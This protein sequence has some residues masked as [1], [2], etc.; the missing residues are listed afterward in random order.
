MLRAMPKTDRNDEI[1][2][3]GQ[4]AYLADQV[5]KAIRCWE[6]LAVNGHKQSQ[7]VLLKV[8]RD[9]R[10][11]PQDQLAGFYWHLLIDAG[12]NED[13]P[14]YQHLLGK[15]YHEGVGVQQ[16]YEKA[17]QC[18]EVAA[19]HGNHASAHQLSELYRDG[20]GVVQSLNM[21]IKW[22]KQAALGQDRYAPFD[23]GEYYRS[24]DGTTQN[25]QQS[26][27]WFEAAH[28]GGIVGAAMELSEIYFDGIGVPQDYILASMWLHIAVEQV[29]SERR[30]IQEAPETDTRAKKFLAIQ[31]E[32]EEN[33]A[34]IREKLSPSQINEAQKRA[35]QWCLENL[36]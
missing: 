30:Y 28:K 23:L 8:Y 22:C 4:E 31:A 5:Q 18:F 19:D 9:G 26:L 29:R 6:P 16:S 25:I 21:A 15:M 2:K 20:R 34:I 35:D 24:G 1:F 32:A 14:S 10:G 17:A 7:A 27:K 3:K 36:I 13:I 12:E 11:I 33:L